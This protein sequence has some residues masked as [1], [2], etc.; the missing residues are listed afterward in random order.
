MHLLLALWSK[1]YQIFL[2]LR[3]VSAEGA[4]RLMAIDP[5]LCF[6]S[7]TELRLASSSLQR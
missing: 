2:S 3:K 7:F 5:G 6:E 4:V 1:G